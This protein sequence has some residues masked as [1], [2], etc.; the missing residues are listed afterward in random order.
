M[1][2]RWFASPRKSPKVSRPHARPWVEALEDRFCPS[3]APMM[4]FSAAKI[5]SELVVSGQVMDEAPDQVQVTLSGAVSTQVQTDSSGHFSFITSSWSGT[6]VTGQAKDVENLTSTSQTATI[7]TATDASPFL[8]MDVAY[9][10]QKQITLSGRLVDESPG[11][12][13]V[14]FSGAASGSVVTDQYG[15]YSITLTASSLGNVY[16]SATDPAG[17]QSNQAVVKLTSDIPKIVNFTAVEGEN[18]EFTFSGSVED[19]WAWGLTVQFLGSV[20]SLNG[21]TQTVNADGTF[22][23]I[24]QLNGTSSD[25]GNVFAGVSDWWGQWSQ[26]VFTPVHQS[27]T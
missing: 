1:F 8:T 20:S 3:A 12:R 17:H 27:G 19:E 26:V 14:T 11:G 13:T 18:H 25:N 21:Q 4:Y 15:D 16:A 2:K 6:S 23:V 22:T 5:G 10:Q 9:G 7:T 24:M